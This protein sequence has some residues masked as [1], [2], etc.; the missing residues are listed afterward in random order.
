M[1]NLVAPERE[2]KNN[3]ITADPNRAAEYR[4]N[5]AAEYRHSLP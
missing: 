1:F 3:V 5:R 2:R 4:H